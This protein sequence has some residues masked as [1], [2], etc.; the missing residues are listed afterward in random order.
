MEQIGNTLKRTVGNNI[1]KFRKE[2][3]IRQEELAERVG[4]TSSTLSKIENGEG[5]VKLNTLE[6]IAEELQV[7]V[8]DLMYE[9]D[10]LVL[11]KNLLKKLEKNS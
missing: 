7:R 8:V 2:A 4:I 10:V 9:D 11:S 1:T 3:K 5:N 6:K